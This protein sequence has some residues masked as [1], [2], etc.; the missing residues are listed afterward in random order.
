MSAITI[1]RDLGKTDILLES[2]TSSIQ[3]EW[4]EYFKDIN[5]ATLFL[6][7]G[8]DSQLVLYVALEHIPNL[9]VVTFEYMWEDTV[10]N[11]YDVIHSQKIAKNLGVD[12]IVEE[13]DFKA[14]LDDKDMLYPFAKKYRI[15]SPQI[16]AFLYSIHLHKQHLSD[17]NLIGGEFPVAGVINKLCLFADQTNSK[18]FTTKG[19]T[20]KNYAYIDFFLPFELLGEELDVTFIKGV[21]HLTPKVAYLSRK[22]IINVI[23]E[24]GTIMDITVDMLHSNVYEFKK[25]YYSSF[26]YNMWYPLA[27][28]TGF[29]LLKANLAMRTGNYD[30]FDLRYRFPLR[31]Q[32]DVPKNNFYKSCFYKPGSVANQLLEDLDRVYDKVKPKSSNIWNYDW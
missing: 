5:T 30:E 22:Q 32:L 18:R 4:A 23:E 24:S 29:E 31:A 2:T 10:I 3:D 16:A 15:T 1:D 26:G 8:L 21:F 7:S 14:F 19:F 13:V 17:T 6:S 20:P 9:K 12:L 27:K 25:L 11:A 28:R